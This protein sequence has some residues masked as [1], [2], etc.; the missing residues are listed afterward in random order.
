[1]TSFDPVYLVLIRN[2]N[3]IVKNQRV[4]E[5][6]NTKTTTIATA[7]ISTLLTLVIVAGMM[8]FY[9]RRNPYEA[10][11]NSTELRVVQN[12][13]I[14]CLKSMS[15]RVGFDI[16]RLWMTSSSIDLESIEKLII[17]FQSRCISDPPL[18]DIGFKNKM[19]W[20]WTILKNIVINYK[21]NLENLLL[22]R[23]I[24]FRKTISA[25]YRAPHVI[26]SYNTQKINGN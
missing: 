8:I 13:A 26:K 17:K 3:V 22:P 14:L 11:S 21:L 2:S 10:F 24:N 7:C 9:H 20:V 6:Q 23:P 19:A 5:E 25:G 15:E 18:S 4:Y 16:E 1:M 12:Q